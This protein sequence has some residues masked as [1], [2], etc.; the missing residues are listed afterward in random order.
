MERGKNYLERNNNN[1]SVLSDFFPPWPCVCGNVPCPVLLD[2]LAIALLIFMLPFLVHLFPKQIFTEKTNMNK[3][4]QGGMFNET[5]VWV[6]AH[7]HS[8]F[9]FFSQKML[10]YAFILHSDNNNWSPSNGYCYCC[11]WC[12][13]YEKYNKCI[14]LWVC[15]CLRRPANT[16]Y[17]QSHTYIS[18][19]Y[20]NN[21]NINPIFF[22]FL[23]SLTFIKC[24][25]VLHST[26]NPMQTT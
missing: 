7:T 22:S 1:S 12:S 25:L 10:L 8:I 2:T 19:C 3:E 17:Y 13:S 14:C 16:L 24:I 5:R 11:W 20:D 21:I 6:R 9:S 15:R 23:L 26:Q 4:Y 18:S